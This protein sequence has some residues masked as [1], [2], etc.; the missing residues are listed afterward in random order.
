MFRKF[1]FHLSYQKH[2]KCDTDYSTA[3]VTMALMGG[4]GLPEGENGQTYKVAACKKY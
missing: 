3:L 1:C 4:Y 2:K